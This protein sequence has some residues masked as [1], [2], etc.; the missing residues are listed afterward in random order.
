MEQK[1]LRK[2][3]AFYISQAV[4]DCLK[5]ARPVSAER[6][7]SGLIKASRKKAV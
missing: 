6:L 5:A 2:K 1:G 3:E 4:A 7:A